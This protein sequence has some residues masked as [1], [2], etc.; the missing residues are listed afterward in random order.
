MHTPS[1]GE[2]EE[3]TPWSLFLDGFWGGLLVSG[4]R[5]NL[6]SRMSA[7]VVAPC[8]AIWPVSVLYQY[9]LA[10]VKWQDANLVFP[11]SIV[12]DPC[13]IDNL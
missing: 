2:I 8:R 10:L 6:V 1:H 13:F 3:L 9:V 4:S 7:V 11:T 12:R 5:L